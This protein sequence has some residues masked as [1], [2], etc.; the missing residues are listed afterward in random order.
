MESRFLLAGPVI[1]KLLFISVTCLSCT[2]WRI[3]KC[4]SINI[5]QLG[6]VK[7]FIDIIRMSCFTTL[8]FI[9]LHKLVL[10]VVDLN[11]CLKCTTNDSVFL[12]IFEKRL[13]TR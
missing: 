11:C 4:Y 6:F 1:S 7:N 10:D 5:L 2:F 12:S 3:V 13:E 8:H 9:H